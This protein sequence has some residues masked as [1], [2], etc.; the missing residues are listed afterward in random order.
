[1][2]P[3]LCFSFLTLTMVSAG[4]V[5]G[6]VVRLLAAD[7]DA[8]TLVAAGCAVGDTAAAGATVGFIAVEPAQPE[9]KIIK[10]ND[11]YLYIRPLSFIA[12]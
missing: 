3:S 7:E 2:L 1:M 4:L 12:P 5:G 9:I 10:R 8:G 11:K 6:G